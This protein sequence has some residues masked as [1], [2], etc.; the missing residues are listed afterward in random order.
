M[1]R[2]NIRDVAKAAGVSVATV[3]KALNGYQDVNPE[4]RRCVL[5]V[6][7]KLN[8]VADTNA[9]NMGGKV[10]T[11]TIALL[12]NGLRSEDP[13]G[14]VFGILSGTHYI[15]KRRNC[16]FM[17]LTTSSQEQEMTPLLQL[18]RQKSVNGIVASGFRLGDPYI[19][20]MK[21]IDLPVA[22]IDMD[23][24]GR[25]VFNVSIDNV[26]AAKRATEVLLQ[27]GHRDVAMLNGTPARRCSGTRRRTRASPPAR[28]G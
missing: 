4:T 25:N 2:T 16:D 27:K 22:F 6:A 1:R 5:D 12:V 17:L 7:N 18:C 13:S 8:Y 15:C 20:Q 11:T 3:S 10:E 26:A 21:E 24:K 28:R 19:E 14:F 9:R 23:E